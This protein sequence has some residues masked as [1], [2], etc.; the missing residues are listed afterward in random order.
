MCDCRVI[1]WCVTRITHAGR[2]FIYVGRINV[3]LPIRTCVNAK[4]KF[5]CYGPGVAQRVGRG[6][7]L[8]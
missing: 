1:D 4:V 8:L 6:I 2:A 7:A 3:V 5:S